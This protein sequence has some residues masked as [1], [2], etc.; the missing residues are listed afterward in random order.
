MTRSLQHDGWLHATQDRLLSPKAAA[1]LVDCHPKT[2]KRWV[3]EFGVGYI[4]P[5]GRVTVSE[6]LLRDFI[7]GRSG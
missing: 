7:M 2:I 5:N 6:A 3:R 1:I 4:A